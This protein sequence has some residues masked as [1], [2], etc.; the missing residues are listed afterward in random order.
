MA[1]PRHSPPAFVPIGTVGEV[2][3]PLKPLGSIHALDEEWS[4]RTADEQPLERGTPVRV[5]G[6]DGLTV[7][8][9]ADLGALP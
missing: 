8:V 5:V 9:E 7:V 3:R 2:R 6:S 1:N 4:A